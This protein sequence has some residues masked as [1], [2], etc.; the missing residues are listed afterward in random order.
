MR[1]PVDARRLLGT[2][3]GTRRTNRTAFD[4]EKDMDRNRPGELQEHMLGTYYGLRLGLA[5]I[6]IALRK[7][8]RDYPASLGSGT[9]E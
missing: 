9:A 6:G 4:Q 1:R 5:V 2:L 8:K 7:P 3:G